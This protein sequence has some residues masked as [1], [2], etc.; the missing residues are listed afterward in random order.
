M[1]AVEGRG[2]ARGINATVQRDLWALRGCDPQGPRLHPGRAQ[3]G[4]REVKQTVSSWEHALCGVRLADVERCADALSCRVKDLP[5][6]PGAP[7]PRRPSLWLRVHGNY[8]SK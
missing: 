6:P 7:L 2:A 8:D 5:A 1:V 3:R 4:G